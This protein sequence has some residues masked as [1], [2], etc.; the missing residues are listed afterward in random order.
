MSRIEVIKGQKSRGRPLHV[1]PPCRQNIAAALAELE[2]GQ[3]IKTMD[4]FKFLIANNHDFDVVRDGWGLYFGDPHYGS[5]GYSHITW[6]HVNGRFA[7]ALLLEYAATLGLI[8]VALVSPWGALNDL[9]T[10]GGRMNCHA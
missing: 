2:T 1:A 8:D 3:W 10:S 5:F 9:G 7:R 6:E 4:F